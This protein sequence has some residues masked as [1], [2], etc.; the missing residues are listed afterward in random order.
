VRTSDS[1]AAIAEALAKFQAAVPAIPKKRTANVPMKSGGSYS[2]KYAD[3]SDIIDAV[4]APLAANGLSYTQ[5]GAADGD[6][7]NCTTLVMHASG[8]F[9][10]SDAMM[11]P[12]GATPQT[13]GSAI[14]YARRYSLAPALGISP[15]EDDD[16]NAATNS[17]DARPAAKAATPATAPGKLTEG[18][19]KAIYAIAHSLGWS[20]EYLH[21]SLKRS[22]GVDHVGDMT[23]ADASALI[24]TL[25]QKQAAKEPAPTPE[26][27]PEPEF[28][29]NAED[30]PF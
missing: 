4:R 23:K 27:E 8:E 16:G 24:E 3:L 15:D 7:I 5:S 10:E 28:D 12:S 18:Q 20:D 9:I 21:A 13:A 29:P 22:K 30:I 1:I 2:Y 14:T 11:L 6:H 19:Q 26:P 17:T 25:K